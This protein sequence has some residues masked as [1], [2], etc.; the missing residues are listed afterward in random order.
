MRRGFNTTRQPT[1]SEGNSRLIRRFSC[2]PSGLQTPPPP[3]PAGEL[4]R[5]PPAFA[6]A[7]NALSPLPSLLRTGK[8][9]S[10]T[11]RRRR[12]RRR[13]EKKKRKRGEKK[14]EKESGSRSTPS[15]RPCSSSSSNSPPASPPCAF[16]AAYPQKPASLLSAAFGLF[17]PPR[18]EGKAGP[19]RLQRDAGAAKQSCCSL[20]GEVRLGDEDGLPPAPP[21]RRSPG[22]AR[23]FKLPRETGSRFS[24]RAERGRRGRQDGAP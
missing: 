2:A 21:N 8:K 19:I 1:S 9:G 12:R 20:L 16:S 13:R 17:G 23:P 3:P 18:S 15:S 4:R 5:P 24:H 7:N 14:R 22:K 10:N 6:V 11:T